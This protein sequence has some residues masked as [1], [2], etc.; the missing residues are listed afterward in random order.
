[1]HHFKLL[2]WPV[3]LLALVTP[4][5]LPALEKVSQYCALLL[6]V[7]GLAWI[8]LQAGLAFWDRWQGRD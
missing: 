7:A 8:G 2:T 4:W 5:W 6:P 3:S 1:M